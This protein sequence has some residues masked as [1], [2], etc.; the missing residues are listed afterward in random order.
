MET[1]YLQTKHNFLQPNNFIAID[2]AT[3]Y[4]F[5]LDLTRFFYFLDI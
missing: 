2:I 4:K 5:V 3:Y 1:V